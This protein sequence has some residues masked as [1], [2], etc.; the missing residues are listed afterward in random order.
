[1][2]TGHRDSQDFLWTSV[3]LV[4]RVFLGAL[5]VLLSVP[6][7]ALSQASFHERDGGDGITEVEIPPDPSTISIVQGEYR[8]VLPTE[9]GRNP[10]I[11]YRHES[12]GLAFVPGGLRWKS[13]EGR[14]VILAGGVSPVS[15]SVVAGSGEIDGETFAGSA[16]NGVR[17]EN[18]Y[19]PGLHLGI[20]AKDSVLRKIVRVDRLAD[21]GA[22]PEGAEYLEVSFELETDENSYFFATSSQRRVDLSDPAGSFVVRGEALEFGN[23][24]HRSFLRPAHVWDRRGRRI[25]IALELRRQGE[26][27]ILTK[28]IPVG[29]LLEADFPVYAD[30][31]VVF[32]SAA[33]FETGTISDISMTPL[34]STRVL[35]TYQDVLNTRSGTAVVA[36]IS[37]T[38]ITSFGTPVVFHSGDTW[39]PSAVTL[40]SSH[41][42]I[43]FADFA[44][45]GTAVVLEISGTTI[46]S[47]GSPAVFNPVSAGNLSAAALDST[48]V[49]IAHQDAGNS[50]FGTAQVAQ[51]SGTTITSY[52][53]PVVFNASSTSAISATSLDG[54][55]VLIGYRPSSGAGNAIVATVSGTTITSF[56]APVTFTPASSSISASALDSTHALIAYKD[57]NNSGFGTAVVGTI[58]GGDVIT[59]GT[60]VVFEASLT[61]LVS[62]A[63][64]DSNHAVIGYGLG[65]FY[66][67]RVVT[68]WGGNRIFFG[69]ERVFDWGAVGALS[70]PLAALDGNRVVIAYEVSSTGRAVVGEIQPTVLGLVGFET[71]NASEINTLGAGASIQT[72]T[73]R[74]GSG[75]NGLKQASTSSILFDGLSPALNT[76]ALRFSFRKPANP[77]SAQTLVQFVDGSGQAQWSLDLL[78]GGQLQ[79]TPVAPLGFIPAAASTALP[80][81]TWFTIRVVYDVAAG[82]AIQVWAGTSLQINVTHTAAG[83][84]ISRLTASG[85]AA[86]NEYFYDDFYLS[87]ASSQ[88]PAGQIVRIGPDGDGLIE[89]SNSTGFLAVDEI[90]P[91][92]ADFNQHAPTSVATDLYTLQSAPAG[93]IN[94]VKGMWRMSR[95]SGSTGGTHDYAWRD[96]GSIKS[97]EFVGLGTGWSQKE[98]LWSGPPEPGGPWSAA[99]VD[100]LELGARHNGTQGQDTLISWTSAMVD[101]DDG[102]TEVTLASFTATGLDSEVVLGWRTA[103]ELDNLGFQLYRADSS[104]GPYERITSRLIPGL[105]SSPEGASYRYVDS[106]LTN[107]RTY[108]Y[109]LED[110]ET[111]GTTKRHGPVSATPESGASLGSSPAPRPRRFSA[112]ILYG[113]PSA[114]SYE[115]RSRSKTESVLELR[116]AGFYAEP[117]E[118]G[119]VRLFVP[120]LSE[121]EAATQTVLPVK[122]VWLEAMAG[123]RVH[124]ASV[125]TQEVVRFSGLRPAGGAEW[126]TEAMP[127]GTVRPVRR[128]LQ[129]ASRR[130][131]RLEPAEAARVVEVGFQGEMKQALLEL[132]PL[133]WDEARG[134]LVLVRRLVVRVVFAGREPKEQSLGGSRGRHPPGARSWKH[135]QVTA[136]LAT[137]QRGLYAVS[138][139][140]VTG[141]RGRG[142]EASAIRLSRGGEPVAF[143]LQPATGV[144]GPGSKLY[145]LSDG[146]GS[147]PYGLEAVYELSLSGGGVR[148]AQQPSAPAGSSVEFYWKQVER[149]ENRYYQAALIEAPDTWLWDLVFAPG[150]KGYSFEVSAPAPRPEPARLEVWLQGASDFPVSPDHHVRVWLNGNLATEVTFDGKTPKRIEAELP[151]PWLK[152][153]ENELRIENMGDTGAPYSMV[154]LDRFRVS[155]PR[156][157]I[158]NNGKLEGTWSESGV[159]RIAMDSKAYLLDVTEEPPRSLTG[160]EANLGELRF[161]VEAGR[162]TLLVSEEAVLRPEVRRPL[163][164]DLKSPDHQADYLLLAPRSFLEAAEP[165]LRLRQSQGLRTRAVPI[166]E[167]FSEFGFGETRPEAIREFLSYAYHFWKRPSVRYVALL[168]DATYDFKGY[169]GSVASNQVPPMMVRTRYLWTASDPLYASV[170]GDDLLPDLAIGRLPAATLEEARWMVEKILAYE[171]TGASTAAPVVLVTDDP[172]PAGN[173]EADAEEIATRLPGS[174]EVKKIYLGRLGVT[175]ARS[176]VAEAFDEGAFLM[177]YVGHGGIHLWADENLFNIANVPSLARQTAQPILLTMNCLN[178][179]FHFP[180]FNSLSEELLKAKDKGVIA[181]F[182]PSGLS[183]D[184]PAHRF[185]QALIGEIFYGAHERLGDA[186]LAAQAAYVL[187]GASPELLA[188]YHVLGDPALTLH[189]AR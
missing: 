42:L 184:G 110:V 93:V 45:V 73:V 142:V 164:S 109:Q 117:Q 185:H 8:V 57:D 22:V 75:S 64:L 9:L 67:T 101:Y 86:P 6:P 66:R 89:F 154:M 146:H 91:A 141:G 161:R 189:H 147:N 151:S 72:T 47:V 128:R 99:K 130:R 3:S 181:A 56:G 153:G 25:P 148:M 124:V 149:E 155:Y 176:A 187:T 50:G 170:N 87:D 129:E 134:E 54:T 46:T 137:T 74:P 144:F 76:L 100:S 85:M 60:P 94:A 68:V 77:A 35:I 126:G 157:V 115:V 103:S 37:G 186:V 82:G 83:T 171:M 143:T 65:S 106:G 104:D 61:P 188:I 107:G 98:V 166:E 19:G 113:D 21:L 183:L 53:A 48:H 102:T 180:Y 10:R 135:T 138:F 28:R 131:G 177:S 119:S 136:R 95:G 133:R 145:F 41:V 174:R 156:R 5:S 132:A 51:I 88:P 7:F 167:V 71:G 139:E 2:S 31:D 33:T 13:S 24:D 118:D 11:S 108:F 26:R 55:H 49:L 175:A 58:S 165:L 79:A 15:A 169:L 44:N 112:S 96:G 92:D 52:G 12:L 90:P 81:D 78:A 17:Y 29:W 40:D 159:A 23:R 16:G 1:M 43:A 27:L 39:R 162:R 150:S 172:D 62:T 97:L 140:E 38:S 32:G 121:S 20:L 36:E 152:E 18:A 14:T 127:W 70:R 116:T 105:G 63:A 84:A 114:N 125:Q 163:P 111:T 59:L 122:P 179:Y 69:S 160:A 158:A 178:G 120:G 30:A 34:D 123:R 80:H 4:L 182:S 168:G 173:F